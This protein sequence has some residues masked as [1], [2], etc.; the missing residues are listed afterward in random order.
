MLHIC[1]VQSKADILLLQMCRASGKGRRKVG[2]RRSNRGRCWCF[3]KAVQVFSLDVV[4]EGWGTTTAWEQ[5]PSQSPAAT[6]GNGKIKSSVKVKQES[7]RLGVSAGLYPKVAWVAKL[8][9]WSQGR[10]IKLILA[11]WARDTLSCSCGLTTS[12]R[13]FASCSWLKIAE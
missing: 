6:H 9:F 11:S 8:E 3:S 12:K 7:F 5:T 2:C 10:K 4:G 1:I 13:E